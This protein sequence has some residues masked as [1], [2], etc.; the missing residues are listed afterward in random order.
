VTPLD[1]FVGRNLFRDRGRAFLTITALAICF[2]AFVLL[3]T[4]TVSWSAGLDASISDRIDTV[5]KVT[6]VLGLP[7]RYVDEIR[8]LPGIRATTQQTWFGG[9]DPAH[10]HEYFETLAVD[11]PSYFDVY[12]ELQLPSDQRDAWMKDRSGAVVGDA[13]AERL[14]WKLGDQ[15]T[16]FSPLFGVQVPLKID[17]I[18]TTTRRSSPRSLFLFHFDYMNNSIAT[19]RRDQV[20][21]ITSTVQDP[22]R[23]VEM[24]RSVDAFFSTRDP[25]TVTQ[26]ERSEAAA[27]MGMVAAVFQGLGIVSLVV[28]FIALLILANT[29]SI[30][31]RQRI[32]EFTVLSTMGYR[33]ARLARYVVLEALT[34]G[35][36]AAALG[37]G[38]AFAAVELVL[39]RW[40]EAALGSY[41]SS[42]RIA[43]TTP[44][45]AIGAAALVGLVA[46][47]W[48][49]Y[50]ASRPADPAA[51]RGED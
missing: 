49:A 27:S 1:A 15:V 25:D 48:P 7:V 2:A 26:D 50:L 51:L 16:L 28:L 22:S 19:W 6:F 11:A 13:L 4:V 18:Y 32:P 35:V 37:I 20:N 46:A 36:L 42:F 30:A 44:L 10:E 43:W 29:L 12:H 24:S 5:N 41:L 21:W 31:A 14:G 47:A 33:G 34:T 40:I 17:G 8:H 3:R 45:R 39:G 23:V 38:L 9:Q